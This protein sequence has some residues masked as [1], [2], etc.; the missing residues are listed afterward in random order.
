MKRAEEDRYLNNDLLAPCQVAWI[1]CSSAERIRLGSAIDNPVESHVAQMMTRRQLSTP[2]R[3]V[4]SGRVGSTILLE[5]PET[6]DANIPLEE[7]AS[8][9]VE[10]ERPRSELTMFKTD[11]SWTLELLDTQLCGRTGNAGWVSKPIGLQQEAYDAEC[12]AL[13]RALEIQRRQ[14]T[15]ERITGMHLCV[16]HASPFQYSDTAT[17]CDQNSSLG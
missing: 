17:P 14:I 5:E 4:G 3:L 11:H 15:P 10:A 8:A 2:R 6:L 13:A 1:R 9:K 7:V 12:A 16:G